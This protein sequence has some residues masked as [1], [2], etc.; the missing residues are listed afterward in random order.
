MGKYKNYLGKARYIFLAG[1]IFL[2]LFTVNTGRY[3]GL[4]LFSL[5]IFI[6]SQLR[7]TYLKN[8]FAIISILF[9]SGLV[10]YCEYMYGGFMFLIFFSTLIDICI[11]TDDEGYLL[12]FIAGG[13]CAYSAYMSQGVNTAWIVSM[14]YLGILFL[15]MGFRKELRARQDT[16]FLYDRIRKY[17]YEL[18]AARARLMDY[19]RQVEKVTQLEER[20]R[21]SRELHDSIGHS[22]A[23]LLM[24]VDACIQ[25]MDVNKEKG[26]EILRSVYENIRNCID[27]VRNT[28]SSMKPEDTRPGL[29]AIKGLIDKF[30][31][32]TGIKVDFKITGQRWDIPPAVG[33]ALYGNIQESLTNSIRHGRCSS[34]IIN[35][36]YRT[37]CLEVFISDN[38]EGCSEIINGYG[39]TGMEERT[40][41]VGGSI[42][43]SGSNGFHIHMILP[44]GE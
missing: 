26:M 36:I 44:K 4:I 22:L 8:N 12:Q 21:I 42:S 1:P 9:E 20:N 16:E 34:I 43:F 5:I 10:V 41:M 35:L 13:G 31:D 2:S 30:T 32:D 14:L 7:I 29:D 27:T 23:G 33:T 40:N 24:Q 18:E 25:V 37:N 17:S 11:M 38:G 6:N 39:L 3:E 28:V 15:L 19:S